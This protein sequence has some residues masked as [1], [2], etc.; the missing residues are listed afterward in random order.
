MCRTALGRATA[1]LRQTSCCTSS[2]SNTVKRFADRK[3]SLPYKQFLGYEKGEDGFPK[4]VPEEAKIIRLI[5]SL[6]M[7]GKSLFPPEYS[8]DI[9]YLL[10]TYRKEDALVLLIRAFSYGIIVGKQQER[11]R[12]KAG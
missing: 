7:E 3:V 10:S 4:I 6:F 1:S 12:R 11:A 9:K 2:T 8:E 5:Y